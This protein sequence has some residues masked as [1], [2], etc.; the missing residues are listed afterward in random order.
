M[1]MDPERRRQYQERAG[2]TDAQ[3]RET[4]GALTV[5]RESAQSLGLNADL[6]DQ[7]R[8]AV[9]DIMTDC[10]VMSAAYNQIALQTN[11]DARDSVDPKVLAEDRATLEDAFAKDYRLTDPAGNTGGRDKTLDAILS[12]KIRKETFGK[13][14]FETVDEEFLVK[15]D[16]AISVG[17]FKMNATQMARNI[18]TGEVARRRRLGT[19]KSTH[20][21]V[22]EGDRWRLAASQL[23]LQPDP[24]NLPTPS[25]AA[26]WVFV[27]D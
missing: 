3:I 9:Q 26:E 10:T 8:T 14:G 25:D 11:R 17:V 6:I 20:T 2:L 4:T 24:D 19:F 1:P 7:A 12:G 5:D 27:D 15:G 18:K 23:T 16:S 21:Y 13:G 22:R